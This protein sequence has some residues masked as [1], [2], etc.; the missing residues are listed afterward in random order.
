[1]ANE[2]RKEP[3]LKGSICSQCNTENKLE[4]NFCKECGTKL[5]EICN[6]WIKGIRFNCGQSKC[7][8][9]QLHRVSSKTK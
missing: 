8:G 3:R 5:V 6:C 2:Q 9:L 1:M 4:A 7:P